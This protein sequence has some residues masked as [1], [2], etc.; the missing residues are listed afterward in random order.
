MNLIISSIHGYLSNCQ[1]SVLSFSLSLHTKI[2]TFY[3]N[4]DAYNKAHKKNLG[5][6]CHQF[7]LSTGKLVV[8]CASNPQILQVFTGSFKYLI[9]RK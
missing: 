1:A 6:Y 9:P 4:L 7:L 3:Q 8:K 2:R 5:I